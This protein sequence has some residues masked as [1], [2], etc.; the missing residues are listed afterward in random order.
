MKPGFNYGAIPDTASKAAA[1]MNK[2][3]GKKGTRGGGWFSLFFW[4]AFRRIFLLD[5]KLEIGHRQPD[6]KPSSA[7]TGVKKPDP[8]VSPSPVPQIV[9]ETQLEHWIRWTLES[10]IALAAALKKLRDAYK[11]QQAGKP[12]ANADAILAEVEAALK[13][14]EERSM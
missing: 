4:P 7:A 1:L 9:I 3:R 13:K 12:V 5:N 8:S 10:N 14:V 2:S 6:P 11:L